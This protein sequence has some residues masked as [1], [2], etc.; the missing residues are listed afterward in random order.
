ME[1]KISVDDLQNIMSKLSNVIKINEEGITGMVLI[2][3]TDTVKFK[4]TDGNVSMV[5]TSD[6]CETITKGKTL[7]RFRDIKGYIMKFIPLVEDYGT[8]DF[9]FIVDANS[10]VIKTKT[11]TPSNKPSYG[12]LKFEVF[13]PE[14]Y[15]IVKE[16]D[17]AHL[18][19]NSVILKKGIGRVLHC[20]NPKEVRKAIT[21]VSVTIKENK[22]VFA[23][24]NGVKLSEFE[25][26]INADIEK[27]SHI[28][29]YNFASIL[30]NVLDDDAQVFIR[31]EGTHVYI[32]SNNIYLIGSLIIGESYPDYKSMFDLSNV[33]RFPRVAFA[34]AVNRVMDVL[35]IEDNSRLTLNFTDN[36]LTL[37]N[38]RV[39]SV[40]EF[41]DPFGTDLDIDVNGE[42]LDSILRDF[43]NEE[44]ELYFTEGNNYIVF[45][46]PENCKH[47]ALLTIVKRR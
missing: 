4:A 12:K 9:H 22:I 25:M 2:E 27:K 10:G 35:D 16:F 38:D 8:E 3:V 23:G 36:I 1:F 28:F 43:F 47:T 17:E 44:L 26:D 34:D 24:T 6:Q 11:Q 39:E 45:R 21:G 20:V 37:K 19:V 14:M 7:T 41:E 13:S 46:S 33:I 18:I 31:F 30:R 5:I 15:P 42:Y 29:S 40:Q 32:K